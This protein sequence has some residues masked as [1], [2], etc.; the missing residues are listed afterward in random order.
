MAQSLFASKKFIVLRRLFPLPAGEEKQY[1]KFLEGFVDEPDLVLTIVSDE[2]PPKA[3]VF[4]LQ[5]SNPCEAFPMPMGPEFESFIRKEAA[6]CGARLTPTLLRDL[7]R[8]FAGDTW[9]VV[10]ELQKIALGG[11]Y[12]SEVKTGT[13]DFFGALMAL[14]GAAPSRALPLLERLLQGD[15]EAKLFN[16]LASRVTLREK[17]RFAD[18]D[19]A[20]K[21]GKTD[22]ALALTDYVLGV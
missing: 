11:V 16:V 21:T 14:Q 2:P 9:G 22:Y 12:A 7:A 10:A 8:A 15:D 3:F 1:R 6:L 19:I 18:Y 13:Q 20:I 4:L 17:V 5:K